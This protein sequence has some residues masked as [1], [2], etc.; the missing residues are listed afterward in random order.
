MNSNSNGP[1]AKNP[2]SPQLP[3]GVLGR[4]GAPFPPGAR[5]PSL[6]A[7]R[8]LTLSGGA[9]KRTFA[10]NVTAPRR[11]PSKENESNANQPDEK[12]TRGDSRGRGGH[13]GRGRGRGR[14]QL[15]Q[16]QGGTFADGLGDG[17]RKAGSRYL[18][19]SDSSGAA[20]ERPKYVP[21]QSMT[22]KD[23]EEDDKKLQLLLRS[24]FIDD[25]DMEV[26]R[27]NP[28]TLPLSALKTEANVKPKVEIKTED[29]KPSILCIKKEK[30]EE[31]APVKQET[32]EVASLG[33]AETLSGLH[34]IPVADLCTDPNLPEV[35]R[36]LFFQLPDTLPGLVP[37]QGNSGIKV[38]KEPRSTMTPSAA[39]PVIKPNPD[40]K[41]EES[42][43]SGGRFKL[44]DFP[45][46]YVGKLQV[47]KSG[48]TR[49][50]LGSVA[51]TLEMGTLL[52]FHQDLA[53]LR[54]PEETGSGDMTILG[55]VPHKLI[56]LPDMEELLSAYSKLL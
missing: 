55:Q 29:V 4:S 36:L 18:S 44:R 7:P 25:G 40:Q 3:R 46:G 5:L 2:T 1:P 56:C 14:G 32:P 24:D 51:L 48:R 9:R 54:L 8:D 19:V 49:L 6:R 27:L 10:P 12:H 38:K 17:T 22:A 31:E 39:A 43:S 41:A 35:G 13:R 42:S 21:T 37:D 20:P 26:T 47:L 45:E 33:S 50:L 11:T 34:R 16:L 23:K 52:S 15:I 53:C 30:K 28:V